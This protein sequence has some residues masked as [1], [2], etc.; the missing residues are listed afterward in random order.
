MKR[1]TITELLLAVTLALAASVTAVASAAASSA[2]LLAP[3]NPPKVSLVDFRENTSLRIDTQSNI[4]TEKPVS[5]KEWEGADEVEWKAA[6]GVTKKNWPAIYVQNTKMLLEAQFELTAEAKEF[7]EK[8][9]KG[10]VTITGELTLAGKA[11]VFEKVLSEKEIQEQAKTKTFVTTGVIASNVAVPARVQLYEKAAIKW[12]WKGTEAGGLEFS[13]AL[14]ESQ[15]NIFTTFAK[16]RASI[17]APTDIYFTLLYLTA[18][19][20]AEKK[21][22]PSELEVIE[23]DWTPF[24]GRE[25]HAINYDLAT[26]EIKETATVMTYYKNVAL[27]TLEK[28]VL[29]GLSCNNTTVESLVEKKEGQ[30]NTWAEAFPYTLAYEGIASE[31]Y[32]VETKFGGPTECE[33][34][35]ACFFIVKNWEFEGAGAGEKP[36]PYFTKEIKDLEGLPGQGTKNPDS[37]FIR[38]FIDKV[39]GVKETLYDPSYGVGPLEAATKEEVF[40]K[41]QEESMAGYC[42]EKAPIKCQKAEAKPQ[43]KKLIEAEISKF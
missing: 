32:S 27:E 24:K 29:N 7:I 22:L 9:I 16:L 15:H 13:Q 20:I 42:V 38:H 6:K 3:A 31:K 12:R 39:K 19:G 18:K 14:G 23:G 33:A 41:Y 37:I 40:L 21:Q 43:K 2:S 34:E 8:G 10:A 30:C 35:L 17:T 11:V 5:I 28:E 4:K 1:K 25:M 26:G 36:F